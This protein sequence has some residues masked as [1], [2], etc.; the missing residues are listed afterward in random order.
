MVTKCAHRDGCIG[1]MRSFLLKEPKSQFLGNVGSLVSSV[2][3]CSID[4]VRF[5]FFC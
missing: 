1:R 4:K 5:F 2:N 3:W